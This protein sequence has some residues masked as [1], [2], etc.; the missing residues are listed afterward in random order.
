[1]NTEQNTTECLDA[2]AHEAAAIASGRRLNCSDGSVIVKGVRLSAM[3]VRQLEALGL[4]LEAYS[5]GDLQ[6]AIAAFSGDGNLID[7]EEGIT[8]HDKLH[9]T[10]DERRERAERREAFR[11]R[12]A[13]LYTHLFSD[14]RGATPQQLHNPW[15]A[16]KV[17]GA[18][19]CDVADDF[20]IVHFGHEHLFVH[21]PPTEMSQHHHEWALDRDGYPEFH[22]YF[23]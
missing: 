8:F 3:L 17:R 19:E 4:A 14:I 20:E 1:M 13:A 18:S 11:Q 2:N 15:C 6:D 7:D 16:A 9:L 5:A 12:S 21:M 23:E 22:H 10:E